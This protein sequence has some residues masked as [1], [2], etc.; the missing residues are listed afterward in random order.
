MRRLLNLALSLLLA[1]QGFVAPA[2]ADGS[3]TAAASPPVAATDEILADA[4]EGLD[5]HGH[6]HAPRQSPPVVP[7]LAAASSES[8]SVATESSTTGSSAG[9]DADCGGG[10]G[11]CCGSGPCGCPCATLAALPPTVASVARAEA[12]SAPPVATITSV[13]PKP[14]L[15][16]LRP[17]IR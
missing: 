9:D 8:G 11:D 7:A 10:C 2:H 1:L 4:E 12:T 15:P 13:A 5:C 6:E 17:P 16:L 3:E 14:S